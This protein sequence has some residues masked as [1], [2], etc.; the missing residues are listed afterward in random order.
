MNARGGGASRTRSVAIVT[1]RGRWLHEEL[2][3]ERS[4]VLLRLENT[5]KFLLASL[6]ER[7]C[8]LSKFQHRLHL[9]IIALCSRTRDFWPHCTCTV[10][11]VYQEF[12]CTQSLDI[13]ASIGLLDCS[14][15]LHFF[16]IQGYKK[17]WPHAPSNKLTGLYEIFTSLYENFTSLYEK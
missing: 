7:A 16:C 9:P 15:S 5:D 1:N 13:D 11:C 17:A 12:V 8:L 2:S 4:L 6:L 14:Y 10:D 3:I